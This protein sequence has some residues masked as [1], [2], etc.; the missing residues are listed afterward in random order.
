[1]ELSPLVLRHLDG[2]PPPI[3]PER[4]L[5]ELWVLNEVGNQEEAYITTCLAIL[6]NKCF[7]GDPVTFELIVSKYKAYLLHCAAERT[8]SKFIK[9]IAGFVGSGGYNSVYKIN[10]PSLRKRFNIQ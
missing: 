1:M 8:A 6:R 3:T 7:N 5:K 10:N 9:R 2:A 4:F